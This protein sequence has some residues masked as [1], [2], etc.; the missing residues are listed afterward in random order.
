MPVG[1]GADGQRS[2]TGRFQAGLAVAPAQPHEPQTGAIALLG[3]GPIG[4]DR[5]DAGLG[6]GADPAS[7]VGQARGGPLEVV[8][9][10]AGPPLSAGIVAGI[11]TFAAF[12][13]ATPL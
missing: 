3:M 7:P 2:P 6:L 5:R 8:L 10:R 9:M 12:G 4:E 13:V 11:I 1:A